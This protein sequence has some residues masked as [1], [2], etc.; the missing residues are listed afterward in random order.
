[1]FNNID[2][3]Y[4]YIGQ[5][6]FEVLPDKWTGAYNYV[7]L[8]DYTSGVMSFVNRYKVDNTALEYDFR[9]DN[10]DTLNIIKAYKDLYHIMQKKTD[11]VPW[12]KA[13]FKVTSEGDFSI[14]FKYDEDFAW[15]NA[16]D[17]DSQ[18]YDNLDIDVINQIET[19]DGLPENAPRYWCKG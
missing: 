7:L 15:Y 13:R 4:N 19:W 14:D 5:S 1:M 3:I 17:I 16:L 9:F 12:N 2:E 11:D 8:D 6:M 18:E 10:K